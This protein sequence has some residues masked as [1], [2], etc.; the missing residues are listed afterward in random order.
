LRLHEVVESFLKITP[1]ATETARGN[2]S[3]EQ[4]RIECA[5]PWSENAAVGLGEQ[6]GDSAAKVCQLIAIGVWEF[7]DEFFAFQ[8]P[9]IVCR[10]PTG[11]RSLEKGANALDQLPIVEASD[12][13]AE[14]D[15]R[16]QNRHHAL[17]AKAKCCGIETFFIN[18]RSSHLTKGGHVRSGLR[19]CSFGVT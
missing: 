13:I 19:V 7:G 12:Q 2:D 4:M 17:F 9:Q 18:R 3:F 14:T 11:I 16:A 6:H 1:G 5:E 15:Q 8:A 10:L